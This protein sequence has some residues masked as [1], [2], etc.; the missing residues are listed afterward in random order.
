LIEPDVSESLPILCFPPIAIFSE[1]ENEAFT[2]ALEPT[3]KF[4]LVQRL[5]LNSARLDATNRPETD[6]ELPTMA[7]CFIENVLPSVVSDVIE[8]LENDC[9]TPP[10]KE[11]PATERNERVCSDPATSRVD[12]T[13]KFS[14]AVTRF[15]AVTS[16]SILRLLFILT[17]PP[18]HDAELTLIELP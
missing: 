9:R 5:S 3:D 7:A 16:P 6:M 2:K 11:L 10:R 1:I 13:F 4:A 14:L 15:N 8:A 18:R 12:P 17:D